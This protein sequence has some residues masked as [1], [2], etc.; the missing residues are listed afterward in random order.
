MT[1]P[2]QQGTLNRLRGSLT[3]PDLPE[4][5]V[6]APFLGK[7]GIAMSFE[8]NSTVYIVGGVAVVGLLAV[9][10]MGRGR[11]GTVT[12]NKRGKRG[13]RSRLRSR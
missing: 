8:G 4:L 11:R 3:I 5:N 13:R 12:A 10:L 6:T 2:V 7:E 1:V 9:L